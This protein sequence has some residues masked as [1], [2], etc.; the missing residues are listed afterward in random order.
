MSVGVIRRMIDG[1]SRPKDS[2][3]HKPNFILEEDVYE[4]LDWDPRL[5]A[6]RVVV[7]A[8]HGVVT[9]TGTV[10]TYDDAR[11]A[12]RDAANVSGVTMLE[13]ELLVGPI[14]AD[15][16][17]ERLTIACTAALDGDRFVPKGAVRVTVR[18]GRVTLSGHVR[19]HRQRDAAEHAVR[20][21]DGVRGVDDE[22]VISDEPIPTDVAERIHKAFQRAALLD[23]TS[24]R[25][26]N[27]G[28]TI[29]LDGTVH[30]YLQREHAVDTAYDAPGVTTVV[31]RLTVG[32]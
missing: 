30:S 18:D 24:I 10:P 21:V 7:K 6:A 17:D 13:N 1:E 12:Y 4:S 32:R 27:S 20:R 5:D 22:I 31:D 14:G 9:L 2:A 19:H 25:V 15:V 23:N 8:D 28:P 29:Y 16:T 3:V 11:R 26:T